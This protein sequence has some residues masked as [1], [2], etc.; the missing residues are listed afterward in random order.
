[1]LTFDLIISHLMSSLIF[2]SQI[3]SYRWYIVSSS[4]ILNVYSHLVLSRSLS[5]IPNAYS[6]HKLPSLTLSRILITYSHIIFSLIF[7]SY[8]LYHVLSSC[9][10]KD[11][12]CLSVCL[13]VCLVFPSHTLSHLSLKIGEG[14]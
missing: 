9:L 13:S 5:R 8:T 10:N 6:H 11:S 3:H 12:F 2:S 4:D 1:M 7:P 14:F